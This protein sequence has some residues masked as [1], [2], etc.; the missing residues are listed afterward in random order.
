MTGK[1]RHII[2]LTVALL[3]LAVGLYPPVPAP[4]LAQGPPHPVSLDTR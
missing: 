1:P 2:V 3:A 4:V